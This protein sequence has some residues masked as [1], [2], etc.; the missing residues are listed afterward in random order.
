MF[1][2]LHVHSIDRKGRIGIPS[3]FR[4]VITEEY[5]DEPLIITKRQKCLV[6]HPRREW[7]VIQERALALPDSN[8]AVLD[9]YRSYIAPAEECTLDRQGRVLI[10]PQLRASA[11]LGQQVM[12][13]GMLRSFEIW[14]RARHEEEDRRTTDNL[15]EILGKMEKFEV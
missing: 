14:D 15:P 7:N 6:A 13:L 8:P 3:K 11:G 9:Y 12:L 5:D 2:G 1:H 10:P 4:K